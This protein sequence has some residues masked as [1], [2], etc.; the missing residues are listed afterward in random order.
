MRTPRAEIELHGQNLAPKSL[1]LAMVGSANHDEKVFPNAEKF[2]IT[3]QPNPHL[4]FGHGIHSCIGA[5]LARM[6]ARITITDLLYRL[7]GLELAGTAP[8]E[9][10]KALHV[11][12]PA[13]LHIRFEPGQ[14]A[15]VSSS[16]N[17]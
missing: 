16:P 4:A 2:D 14:R 6:E 11:H 8:W 3:R 5:A 15:G 12:G 1:I 7:K 9:P 13:R 10:R 17:A